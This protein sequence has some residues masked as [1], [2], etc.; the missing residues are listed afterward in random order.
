MKMTSLNWW[1]QSER[2]RTKF[3]FFWFIKICVCI[4]FYT[5][6]W[7][8]KRTRFLAIR[9]QVIAF[10][11]ILTDSTVHERESHPPHKRWWKSS[12]CTHC[13]DGDDDACNLQQQTTSTIPL[14][15]SLSLSPSLSSL[16]SFT[17]SFLPS[18]PIS[19][20]E[21]PLL[22]ISP[23]LSHPHRL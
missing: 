22:L 11:V 20:A 2:N 15:L 3:F 8:G 16:F 7:K 6:S 21:F 23:S 5:F 13:D 4:I 19:M 12:F 18:L 10:L 14:S 17:L 9:F 1:Q